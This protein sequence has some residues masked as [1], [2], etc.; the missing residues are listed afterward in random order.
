MKNVSST[1]FF[2][3]EFPCG[4]LEA[5]YDL[6]MRLSVFCPRIPDLTCFRKAV[7]FELVDFEAAPMLLEVVSYE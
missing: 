2:S 7:A 1:F 4:I 3:T 5:F 6:C